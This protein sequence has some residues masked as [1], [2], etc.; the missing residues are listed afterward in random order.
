VKAQNPALLENSD[1]GL[2]EKIICQVLY[3]SLRGNYG[4]EKA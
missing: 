1:D 3:V 4:K 2:K